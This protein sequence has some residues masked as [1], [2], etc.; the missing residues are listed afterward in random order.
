MIYNAFSISLAERRRTP[1]HAARRRG[2]PGT[3]LRLHFVRSPG[4]RG[5]RHPPGSGRR[6]CGLALTFALTAP[7]I[8]QVSE[9]IIDDFSLT[10]SVRPVWLILSAATAAGGAAPLRLGPRP[11]CGQD[12]AHRRHRGAG[13]VRLSRR[14]LRGGRLF[15]RVLGP[16]Y[17]LARKNARR[18][19]HRY[20]ATLLSLT[21]S[22]VLMVTASG[23]AQYLET[24]YAMGHRDSDYNITAGWKAMT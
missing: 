16:E 8:R 19:I 22:V 12:R 3:A 4:R 20:R 17:V 2:H 18:S 11:P 14:A 15:G 13:E 24:A 7:L 10:L 6:L 9:L 5:H 23:F 1:G 21:M